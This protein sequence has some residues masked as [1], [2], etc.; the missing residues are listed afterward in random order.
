LGYRLY[1]LPSVILA[2]IYFIFVLNFRIIII[3]YQN[4]RFS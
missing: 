2:L 3:I 1:F 4:G